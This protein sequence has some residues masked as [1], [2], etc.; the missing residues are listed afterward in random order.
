MKSIILPSL[1]IVLGASVLG[2]GYNAGR[3]KGHLDIRKPYFLVLEP[4][5]PDDP[6][7]GGDDAGDDGKAIK[8]P[9][10]N[11]TL[12]EMV[13]IYLSAAYG[14]GETVFVDARNDEHFE[15]AHIPGAIHIDRYDSDRSFEKAEE[16]LQQADL[17]IVYCGGG[18][19]TDSILLGTEFVVERMIPREKVRVFEGGIAEWLGDNLETEEGPWDE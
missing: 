9:F 7:V 15:E 3:S 10:P 12:D 2:L 5:A 8:N 1:A 18:D 6:T 14:S 17:I 19:C 11:V 13:G 4:P 16:Y